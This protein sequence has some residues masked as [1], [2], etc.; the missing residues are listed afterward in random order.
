MARPEKKIDKDSFENL[1]TLQC[2]KDDIAGFFHVSEKT[3]QNYCKKTYSKTFS[4]ISDEYKAVGRVSLRRA[5]FAAATGGNVQMLIH[6]GKQM[7]GQTDK[8]ETTVTAN[9]QHGNISRVII[10]DPIT[11]KPTK[12]TIEGAD[13][14]VKAYLQNHENYNGDIMSFMLPEKDSIKEDEITGE[15]IMTSTDGNT[16]LHIPLNGREYLPDIVLKNGNIALED[17]DD[18]RGGYGE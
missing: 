16:R 9:I 12:E 6:L 15:R 5:Q 14:D 1:L 17:Y 4:E 18:G 3:L 8:M 7:L 10:Y 2:T 11:G 13:N